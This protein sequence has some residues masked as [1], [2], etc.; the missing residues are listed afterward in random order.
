MKFCAVNGQQQSKL[1]INDRGLAYGDGVFTTAKIINGQVVLLDK[2]IERLVTGCEKLK[3]KSP[4]S[5]YLQQQITF[6]VKPFVKAVLKVMIT[7]GSGGRGYSRVGLNADSAN[8]IIMIMDYPDI[9]E[10]MAKHG[11]ILG[12]SE[13][14]ISHSV[15]LGGIKHLNR[16][17]QV[18]FRAELDERTEDDLIVSDSQGNAIEATSSNV[19]YWLD[20][21]LCTPEITT[22]G[23]NGIIRQ[24]IN[25]K[26][27][28]IRIC[29]TSLS[30]LYRAQSMFVCNSL[31]GIIPV[32]TYNNR[33][34]AMDPVFTLQ[35]QMKGFI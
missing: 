31:M 4:T 24:C 20:G 19:F 5:Q 28:D 15:M 12:N 6:A 25:T 26:I 18:L 23:I 14:H 30:M 27:P 3:I 8:T 35:K 21:Q 13:Q 10:A 2:H 22:A 17:E 11:I 7:T 32:K 34:L 16:L 29:D 33:I 9:Y 1:S